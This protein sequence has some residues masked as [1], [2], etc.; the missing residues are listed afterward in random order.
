MI[1][2]FSGRRPLPDEAWPRLKAALHLDEDF[3]FQPEFLQK[4]TLKTSKRMSLEDINQSLKDIFDRFAVGK[5]KFRLA[6]AGVGENEVEKKAFLF[7]DQNVT[8]I[9]IQCIEPLNLIKNI[10][11]PTDIDRSNFIEI[12]LVDFD[13]LF[14]CKDSLTFLNRLIDKYKNG[15]SI[16][17]W[18][19]IKRLCRDKCINIDDIFEFINGD[20]LEVINL[21]KASNVNKSTILKL[22]RQI[23]HNNT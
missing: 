9:L 5:V 8:N 14:S 7:E 20:W 19:R 21:V 10:K 18:S 13:K 22:I 12:P 17:T 3:R 15:K 4:F 11:I 6:L 16:V 1:S 23:N 2:A